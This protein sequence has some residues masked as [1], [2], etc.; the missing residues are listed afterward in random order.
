MATEYLEFEGKAQYAQVYEPDNAF[1]ASNWKINFFPKDEAEM[2]RIKDAGVQKKVNENNDPERGP[3]GQYIQFT[4]PVMKVMNTKEGQKVVNFSGP[5]I[6]D[7]DGNVI[8]DYIDKTENKRI[9]S[10]SNDKKGDVV[11][12]GKPVIIG[13]SSDVKVRVAIY[14]TQKG[15]GQRLEQV[16]I[17][18]LV[19]YV[20]ADREL[21]P[22]LEDVMTPMTLTEDT[23]GGGGGGTPE[24]VLPW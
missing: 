4:R 6:L 13:N 9:Y 24:E 8:V 23:S 19:P 16:Q 14:D 18:N 10:F 22:V 1:G 20:R 11:R 17:M 21:P 12:R 2:K 15:K 5:V 3:I 7:H